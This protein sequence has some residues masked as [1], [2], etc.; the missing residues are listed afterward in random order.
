[1]VING[2]RLMWILDGYT[3]T[4]QMPF[5]AYSD[6]DSI[7]G[8][9]NYIR[10]PVKVVIDAYTGETNAYAIQPDEPL[11][12]TYE[13]IY[14]GLIQNISELP[15]GLKEHFRY[16]E[17]MFTAQA[18]QVIQYHVTDPL[19]FLNNEDAWDM[20]TEKGASGAEEAMQP[21]YV[22]MR[23]P[24]DPKDEFLLILPFTPRGKP[25]MS[26]WLAA[27]CDPDR[28][29]KLWLYDYKQ[30]L[31][32]N[33]PKQMEAIFNQSPAVANLN[34]LLRNE[35]S[36]PTVGNLIVVPIGNS[37]LYAEPMFLG[38]AATGITAIPELRKVI[39]GLSTGQ[40]V[41]ADT[42]SEALK[43]LFGGETPSATSTTGSTN[44]APSLSLSPP[45]AVD[46]ATKA[47]V[48]D[49]L[50]TADQADAALRQGDFA[51]YGEYQKE[52][53]AK[54]QQMAK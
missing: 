52:L 47:A 9:H 12:Q 49:L 27:H 16:P 19:A 34:T 4:D 14:P 15:A 2:G 3:S 45:V 5:S 33:G 18:R 38:S 20:P 40:I 30:G 29:G 51:K 36:Q 44:A 32:I 42:Y 23:L 10:N 28:Y 21:Y 6:M 41:V 35:Q 31:L 13:S 8:R 1:M 39:L 37:V 46:P 48:Q 24:A 11:L 53:R 50:K 17:D 25:N 7:P 54:L 43:E 26:G 22:Q